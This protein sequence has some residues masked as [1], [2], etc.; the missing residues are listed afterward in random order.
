MDRDG[1]IAAEPQS[2][3]GYYGR[4]VTFAK[5]GR[6]D[7]ALASYD[8]VL[9][10]APEHA[11]ALNE[12][13]SVLMRLARFA[14]ALASIDRAL[15]IRSDYAEAI[16]NRG[17]ALRGL[18]I[19]DEALASYDKAIALKPGYAEAFNNR[20]TVLKD[21]RR[22]DE[23]LASAQKAQGYAPDYA[24]AH[25]TEAELR[26][27][28]N[29]FPAGW[30][31]YEWRLKRAPWAARRFS[32]P[33]WD[34]FASLYDRTILLHA[35]DGFGDAIQFCRYVPMV[36]ARGATVILEV[37]EP[38]QRLLGS[39]DGV[40]RIVGT[41]EALP[42]FEL[43]CPLASLPGAFGTTADTIP[44]ATPYLHPDPA[45]IAGWQAR[46]NAQAPPRIGVAWAG[47]PGRDDD[48]SRSIA[49]GA[50]TPVV[51][52]GATIV[53]LQ[54]G[55]RLGDTELIRTPDAIADLGATLDDF[56]DMAALMSCIDLVI[57]VDASIAHLAGALAKPVFIL[58]PYTPDWRWG[59]E[60]DTSRWYPSA[61]LFRQT[62][63]E[64]WDAVVARAATAAREFLGLGP[65][66]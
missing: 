57:S 38:L 65:A 45:A 31:K 8:H 7:E 48:H 29:D 6:L 5:L 12:R 25:C 3:D 16:N 20:A 13:G 66:S 24:E 47:E 41:G 9:A 4:A 63:P 2:A 36:A 56:A 59:I 64:S 15:A 11:V 61:R 54:K 34:G 14:E 33:Q 37:G 60:G 39:L 19:F 52:I 43:H 1:A 28:L 21:L 10:L 44:A 55:L 35:E 17:R 26:L 50:L 53:T 23:A 30:T 32:Q 42:A 46:L 51:G 22:F 18:N 58:L 49:P 62:T 27:L 40:A